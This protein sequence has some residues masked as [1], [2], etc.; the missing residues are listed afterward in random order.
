MFPCM[1]QFKGGKG[2]LSGGAVAIMIDWRIAVVV[3]GGFLILF[4]LTRYVSLG[5]LWAG[6]SF[7]FAS[8]FVY[9]NALIFLLALICGGLVVWKHRSN[10]ARLVKGEES[11]FSF[12]RKTS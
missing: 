2:I 4:L 7:P 6:A 3:W 8:L 9:R 12:H 1:F 10:L 5:S 11:K